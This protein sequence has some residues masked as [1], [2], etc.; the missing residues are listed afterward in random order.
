MGIGVTKD[1]GKISSVVGMFLVFVEMVTQAPKFIKYI[2][3]M[4]NL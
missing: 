3:S 1:D 2:L 4:I